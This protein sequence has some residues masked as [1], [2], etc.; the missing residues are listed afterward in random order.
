M[1]RRGFLKKLG[2]GAAG[3]ATALAVPEWLLNI[4][5]GRSMIVVPDFAASRKWMTVP[6]TSVLDCTEG[7][8]LIPS[9][10]SEELLRDLRP[11]PVLDLIRADMA[12]AIAADA[13]K[14]FLEGLPGAK[15]TPTGII[16]QRLKTRLAILE[17]R[18]S[19][20]AAEAHKAALATDEFKAALEKMNKDFFFRSAVPIRTGTL[21]RSFRPIPRSIPKDEVVVN[22]RC[23]TDVAIRHDESFAIL[24]KGAASDDE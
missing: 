4:P 23:E 3:A 5:K 2:I 9:N 7:G 18:M 21:R 14:R 13:E 17:D 6:D 20:Y 16:N 22:C 15:A 11:N 8:F 19:K 12:D 24:A 1:N 10:I